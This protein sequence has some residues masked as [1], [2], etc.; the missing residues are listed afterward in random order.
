MKEAGKISPLRYASVE[1]TA[2]KA[3]PV[4]MTGERA[5]HLEMTSGSLAVS[6]FLFV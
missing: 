1:M 2:G 3:R 5:R 4:E 6:L